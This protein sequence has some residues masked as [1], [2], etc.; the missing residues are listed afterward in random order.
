MANIAWPSNP[1]VGQTYTFNSITYYWTGTTW[2]PGTAP[3]SLTG[4]TGPTGLTGPTSG[5]LQIKVTMFTGGTGTFTPDVNLAYAEI[6]TV[7]GGGGGGGAQGISSAVTGGGGGGSGGYSKATRTKAQIGA[8]ILVTV[9]AKGTGSSGNSGTDGGD[10]FVGASYGASICGAKAGLGGVRCVSGTNPKS[11]AGGA[12][13]IGDIVA[14][15]NPGGPGQDGSGVLFIGSNGNGG[16]SHFGGGGLG[17]DVPST[18]T[19]GGNATNYGS[20]GGGGTVFNSGS[21]TGGDGSAGVVIF[22]EFIGGGNPGATGP[23]GSAVNTGATGPTGPGKIGYDD[24]M[25][26]GQFV[27]TASAGAL[28]IA[29]KNL[30]G[31]DP[32]AGD[33][34]TVRFRNVTGST[35]DISSLDITAATSLVISSGS[36]LGVTSTTA[37]RLWIVGFNDAGTFRLGVVKARAADNASIM[38]LTNDAVASSTAEG[39]AGGADSSQVIYTGTAVSSK[40]YRILA[41]LEWDATGL[42]AGTWTTTHLTKNQL[43]GPGVPRPND[44]IQTTY[45]NSTA[46]FSTT[47]SSYVVTNLTK[48]IV[49]TSAA[50]V[51]RVNPGSTVV[52]ANTGAANV[53]AAVF[54]AGTQL[55]PLVSGDGGS[56]AGSVISNFTLD[57][58]D[59]PNTLGSVTYDV[60]VHN[61]DGVT[62]VR[63]P[64]NITGM[65][66]RIVLTELM[67]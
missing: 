32:S 42:T 58:L 56:G 59:F 17:G 19:P 35:G 13:G 2:S 66:A 30:A 22:T 7:G 16:S 64:S 57:F 8:S 67:T 25:L 50:N 20:G 52:N 60:R 5:N 51:V 40:A 44:I 63:M 33:P 43:F 55:V 6:E 10:T 45:F 37:F 31:N 49:I 39:G 46:T 14:G 47:S 21:D 26:N 34:V 24:G 27:V 15:G 1:S 18:T 4:P 53:D 48:A 29:L 62:T 54:R 38:S 36:T 11:G 3:I 65:D 23:A 12:P 61:S 28:T 9:G 41:Y